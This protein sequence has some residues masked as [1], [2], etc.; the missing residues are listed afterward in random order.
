MSRRTREPEGVSDDALEPEVDAADSAASADEVDE[1][2]EVDLD[3]IDLTPTDEEKAAAK[4]DSE[5][6]LREL[7]VDFKA[8][9]DPGMREKLILHYSPLVKYVAGRVGV[10]L[11]P[12]I[13]SADLVSYGIFGLIDAIEKFDLERAIKFETYAINR[14]RGAIIDE[15]RSIDWIPRSVRYKAREVE[16]A[17]QALEAK[18]Q[19]TPTEAE[20]AAQMGVKLEE[21]HAIFSQVSFVN[22]VALDELL[23]AGGERGDKMTL[24]DTLE[25]PKAPD[26]IN[27]FEGEETK[28]ILAQ[29]INT[30]P[31]REKIVV[32]LYYYEG[33]TLAEIGQ[34]LGVTES[35]ICQMHTKA[36]LQLRAKLNEPHAD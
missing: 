15:L 25:D 20:V 31:E 4:A 11:P 8:T 18:L 16:K 35:R 29:A 22:V 6:K 26:P 36:V 23:H 34:V 17:Y 30:L 27:L 21:L 2:D 9:G 33:L 24:G 12:N 3:A 7:W 13:E 1:L 19:R 5:A 28:F 10:G 32:T 14:I